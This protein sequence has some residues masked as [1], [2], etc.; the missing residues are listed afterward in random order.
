MIAELN[1]VIRRYSVELCAPNVRNQNVAKL[2]N[3]V[4]VYIYIMCSL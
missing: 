2:S 4:V 3:I 1:F